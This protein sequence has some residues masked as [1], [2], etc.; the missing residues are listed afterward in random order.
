MALESA[1]GIVKVKGIGN[2]AAQTGV[3]NQVV[4][5]QVYA[6]IIFYQEPAAGPF[7][8]SAFQALGAV[9]VVFLIKP[10]LGKS[11]TGQGV[12]N[13]TVLSNYLREGG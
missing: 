12:G 8:L 7:F 13:V 9:A 1:I 10:A 4:P 2:S 6:Q 11:R 3:I 5:F